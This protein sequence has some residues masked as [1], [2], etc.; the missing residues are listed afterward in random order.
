MG[1]L[2]SSAS[3]STGCICWS[4]LLGC[5]ISMEGTMESNQGT[6]EVPEMSSDPRVRVFRRTLRGLEDFEGMEVDAYVILGER[7]VVLLDTLLCPADMAEIMRI[8]EPELHGGQLLCVNS[9]A[10][11]DHTWGN[12]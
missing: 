7:Y 5:I 12:S 4:H 3:F 8:I 2:F 6:R 1:R 10:D 11:W 9:H